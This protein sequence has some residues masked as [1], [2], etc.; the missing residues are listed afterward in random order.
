MFAQPAA[1][2]VAKTLGSLKIFGPYLLCVNTL[3]LRKNHLRLLEA[4]EMG[5]FSEQGW[6][7]VL[8]GHAAGH[9]SARQLQ[10]GEHKGVFWL[11]YLPREQLVHLFYG[12]EAVLNPSLYEGFGLSTAEAIAAGKP[13]LVSQRSP[14]AEVARD[15]AVQVDPW[16]IQS[17]LQGLTLMIKDVELRRKLAAYN[18]SQRDDFSIRRMAAD[19]LSAYRS[20]L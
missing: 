20:V 7:L 8:V 1:E 4:W 2:D 9:P 10:N 3:N 14:M 6:T 13:V 12:C 11:G 5:G 16:D 15:G 17:I 19:L 18:W